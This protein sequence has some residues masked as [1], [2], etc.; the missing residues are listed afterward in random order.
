MSW[1]LII[2]WFCFSKKLITC[3]NTQRKKKKQLLVFTYHW[4]FQVIYNSPQ[5]RRTC[6]T[7]N[8]GRFQ[9]EKWQISCFTFKKKK[10]SHSIIRSSWQESCVLK[11]TQLPKTNLQQMQI[12][13]RIL[14]LTGI[15][16][17]WQSAISRQLHSTDRSHPPSWLCGSACPWCDPGLSPGPKMGLHDCKL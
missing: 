1:T 7:L 12:F 3:T 16:A 5:R 17:A 15:I 13:I 9:P 14:H 11:Q 10:I 4:N 2:K 6:P 8:Q